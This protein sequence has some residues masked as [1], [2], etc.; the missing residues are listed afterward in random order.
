MF[1]KNAFQIL[2]P[3]VMARCAVPRG[4]IKTTTFPQLARAASTAAATR[5]WSLGNKEQ[6]PTVVISSDSDEVETVCDHIRV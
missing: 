4:E 6:K 5:L 2:S 3:A 1:S